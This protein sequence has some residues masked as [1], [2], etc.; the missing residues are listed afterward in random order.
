[1]P[2]IR[3]SLS[4][5]VS[6]SSPGLSPAHVYPCENGPDVRFVDLY[7]SGLRRTRITIFATIRRT[8]FSGI[9]PDSMRSSTSGTSLR[10]MSSASSMRTCIS[11]SD[12]G[13]SPP[14]YRSLMSSTVAHMTTS[15]LQ[16]G[17]GSA[18]DRNERLNVIDQQAVLSLSADRNE[19]VLEQG[20][21][22]TV[23]GDGGLG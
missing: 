11:A 10:I 1:M 8:R 6:V 23:E 2:G 5:S 13:R 15:L 22:R 3:S 14:M 21:Q 16:P 7:P 17:T 12:A 20:D 9:S 4:S 19:V 18:R